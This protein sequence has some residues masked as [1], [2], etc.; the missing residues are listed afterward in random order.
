MTPI[1]MIKTAAAFLRKRESEQ[2]ARPA[3]P[4]TL[5]QSMKKR[6]QRKLVRITAVPAMTSAILLRPLLLLLPAQLQ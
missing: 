3:S 1:P 4:Q 5:G 6:K 2:T